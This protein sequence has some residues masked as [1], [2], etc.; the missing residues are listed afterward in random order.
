MLRLFEKKERTKKKKKEESGEEGN[1]KVKGIN[2]LLGD[3]Q[4]KSVLYS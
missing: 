4:P 2:W 3:L 1:K